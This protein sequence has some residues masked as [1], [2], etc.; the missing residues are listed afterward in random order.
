MSDAVIIAA[1]EGRRLGGVAKALLKT[2]QTTFLGRIVEL[3]RASGAETIVVVVGRPHDAA[4]RAEALRLGIAGA[5]IV[6]NPGPERGMSTSIELGFR[7]IVNRSKA[8]YL[9]PVDHPYVTMKT[10]ALLERGLGAHDA[11]RPR[12]DGRGG[13][14]PLIGSSLFERLT[15]CSGEPEGARTVLSHADVVEV[16]VDDSGVVR[17]IDTPEDLA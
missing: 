1:G 11:A 8:A 13:H 9:W 4:V 16:E 2:A 10:L 3:A 14:P 12:F 15:T 7:S 17:D 6:E 5:D